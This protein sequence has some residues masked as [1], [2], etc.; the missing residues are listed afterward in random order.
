MSFDDPNYAPNRVSFAIV[1]NARV[2]SHRNIRLRHEA[3]SIGRNI[4]GS[5]G[6]DLTDV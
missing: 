3:T 2:L 6:H 1:N 4:R 5:K